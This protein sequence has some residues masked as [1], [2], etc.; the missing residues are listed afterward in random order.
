MESVLSQ[1]STRAYDDL[2]EGNMSG[3][4]VDPLAPVYL[5]QT[6]KKNTTFCGRKLRNSR[7]I[8]SEDFFF[9]EHYFLVTQIRKFGPSVLRILKKSRN[10]PQAEKG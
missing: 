2:A 10:L 5:P 7:Q 8:Q 1:M 9:R 3:H 6:K 4:L